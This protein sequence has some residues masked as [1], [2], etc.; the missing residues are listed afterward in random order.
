MFV[1]AINGKTPFRI[2]DLSRLYALFSQV[3][4]YD[5]SSYSPAHERMIYKK[6]QGYVPLGPLM[7]SKT[8]KLKRSIRACLHGG[9][10]PQVGGVT[11]L[12]I[13]SLILMWSRLHV[14]WGNPPHVTSPTWGPPPSC[15]QALKRATLDDLKTLMA[16]V[17]AHPKKIK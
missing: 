15:K 11:R 12:S 8:Q 13:Q 17:I 4:S 7:K 14:R 10:G 3:R 16:S 5:F 9:G 1:S 6:T 2:I